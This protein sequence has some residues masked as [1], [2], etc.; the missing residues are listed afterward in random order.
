MNPGVLGLPTLADFLRLLGT[1]IQALGFRTLHLFFLMRLC[2][3][4]LCLSRWIQGLPCTR[5]DACCREET[6]GTDPGFLSA[7]GPKKRNL[8]RSNLGFARFS[9]FLG[10]SGVIGNER[11]WY[12]T[13]LARILNIWNRRKGNLLGC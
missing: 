3:V 4:L 6:P 8:G 1:K 13:S 9:K 10:V 12:G 7:E 5:Q 11:P 2:R